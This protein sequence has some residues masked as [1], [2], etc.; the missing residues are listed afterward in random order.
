M[1]QPC[2]LGTDYLEQY[3]CVV[4]LGKRIWATSQLCSIVI[5]YPI[6]VM[7]CYYWRQSDHPWAPSGPSASD[8]S[9]PNPRVVEQHRILFAHSLSCVQEGQIAVQV[10]NST[11]HSACQ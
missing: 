8:L 5:R 1:T 6:V 9:E 4:D 7:S 2:L 3:H 11:A 10:L